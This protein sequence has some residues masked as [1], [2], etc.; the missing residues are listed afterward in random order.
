[1]D[2]NSSLSAS[3][4]RAPFYMQMCWAVYLFTATG[5]Q[6]RIQRLLSSSCGLSSS[7]DTPKYI[8][9]SASLWNTAEG[10]KRVGGAALWSMRVRRH[11]EL[12]WVTWVY[13]HVTVL[14]HFSLSTAVSIYCWI[15]KKGII[16]SKVG[17]KLTFSQGG[18]WSK[19]ETVRFSSLKTDSTTAGYN[20][21]VMELNQC[22]IFLLYWFF[23]LSC[24]DCN[25]EGVFCKNTHFVHCSVN[26]TIATS[27]ADYKI[28]RKAVKVFLLTKEASRTS[29]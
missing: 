11:N 20:L 9:A 1:M 23:L 17:M 6:V 24:N 21:L 13:V 29:H 28:W 10:W 5:I 22:K 19:W 18:N 7:A 16:I 15:N 2:R 27:W 26:W 8:P 14:E 25:K 3:F 4:I 12:L